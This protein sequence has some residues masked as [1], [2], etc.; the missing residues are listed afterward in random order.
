MGMADIIQDKYQILY[1]VSTYTLSIKSKNIV[2]VLATYRHF[3]AQNYI[4]ILNLKA[5]T[6]YRILIYIYV[7]I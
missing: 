7:F 5:I 4:M 6:K 3:R 2:P 1:V